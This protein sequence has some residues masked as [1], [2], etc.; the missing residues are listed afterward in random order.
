[1]LE[2][3]RAPNS[4]HVRVIEQINWEKDR[5]LVD[6][7]Q[8]EKNFFCLI[9]KLAYLCIR[10]SGKKRMLPVDRINKYLRYVHVSH[11]F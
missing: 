5:M 2:V 10:V 1:M 4:L 9:S 8:R 11:E 3:N 7:I 6:Y